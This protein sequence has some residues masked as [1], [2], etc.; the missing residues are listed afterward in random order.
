VRGAGQGFAD[1]V[2]RVWARAHPG[3][4]LTP[5]NMAPPVE[6]MVERARQHE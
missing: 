5:V 6:F 4:A 3:V 2:F 1:E